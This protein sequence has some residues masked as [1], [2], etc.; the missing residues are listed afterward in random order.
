MHDTT[1][2]PHVI[3]RVMARRG[4]LHIFEGF[5][6]A[7]TA[8][9]V[10]DM[11]NS[12]VAPGS[13]VEVPAARGIVETINRLAAGVRAAGGRVIWVR[14]V[15]EALPGG[16][17]W[18][19]FYDR[20]L[21]DE[22]RARTVRGLAEDTAGRDL[23]PGMAPAEGDIHL[24]KNRYSALIAGSSGLER[25]LRSLG[26]EV[27]LIAG[28]KTNIC[29]ESTARDAMMLDFGVVMVAD[30]NAALSDD[31]HRAA[32]ETVIQNFGDVMTADEVLARLSPAAG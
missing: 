15:N 10:I 6:P 17:D 16:T 25:V 22:M 18:A 20:F 32:L 5:D 8:L 1:I 3:E 21:G 7:R 23:W 30:G 12:F 19:G 4:R 24:T 28:T 9:V 14:H 2:R 13:P 29:C 31:E 27:L 11:Q 26:V